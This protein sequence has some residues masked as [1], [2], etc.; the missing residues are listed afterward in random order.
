MKRLAFITIMSVLFVGCFGC[1]SDTS[2]PISVDR[3][4]FEHRYANERFKQEGFSSKDAQTAADAV[5]KFN[6]AQKARKR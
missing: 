3:G 1:G 6:Q 4:S 2:A 5:Y